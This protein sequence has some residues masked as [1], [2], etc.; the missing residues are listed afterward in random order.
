MRKLNSDEAGYTLILVL[1]IV[2][3][4][5]IFSMTLMGNLLNSSAQNNKTEE[6]I[7]VDNLVQMGTEYVDRLLTDS[8]ENTKKDASFKIEAS[9]LQTA[10]NYRTAFIDELF[11]DNPT[12]LSTATIS[13]ETNKFT[14]IIDKNQISDVT[15]DESDIEEKYKFTITYTITPTLKGHSFDSQ[16]TTEEIF[17]TFE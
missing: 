8:E 9:D 4:F 10:K 3:L 16:T 2:L 14:Y 7:Q 5:F 6:N 12:N 13:I 15:L 17:I 1:L 11:E